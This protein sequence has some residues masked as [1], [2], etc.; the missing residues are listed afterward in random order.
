M[1]LFKRVDCLSSLLLVSVHGGEALI[2]RV[3]SFVD[4][5]VLALIES[6]AAIE[7]LDLPIKFT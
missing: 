2:A 5:L 6:V 1:L 4:L 3:I 7:E